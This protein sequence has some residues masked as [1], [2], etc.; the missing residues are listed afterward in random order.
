MKFDIGPQITAVDNISEPPA[1]DDSDIFIGEFEVSRPTIQSD[2]ILYPENRGSLN[3][4][5]N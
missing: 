1:S 4:S 3:R 2:L 5:L